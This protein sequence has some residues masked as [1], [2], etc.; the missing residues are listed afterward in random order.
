MT[1]RQPAVCEFLR[2]GGTTDDLLKRYGVVSKRHRAHPNLV[3]LKYNQIASP[4]HE[5]IVQ[6][7][8][9]IVL[10]E[11]DDW[12]V[13]SRA[14]NKFFNH[15][16]GHAAEID[17]ATARVQEKLDGSLCVLYPYAGAWYVAT[18]GT[19][20]GSGDVNGHGLR[21]SDY[22]HRTLASHVG[23]RSVP[24]EAG[25]YCFFF[26]LTGPINRVVVVHSQPGLTLL[27]ARRRDTWAEVHPSAVAHLFPGVPV[28]REYG[29]QSVDEI[30]ASFAEMSP[31]SQIWRLSLRRPGLG[32][33]RSSRKWPTTSSG[34]GT[35]RRRRTSPSQ[36]PRPAAPRRSSRSE[37]VRP[38]RRPSF[39]PASTSTS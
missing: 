7:C 36:R 17:W 11:A 37:T 14:F 5:S 30:A 25:D 9:G 6:E 35:S 28:V 21:F 8:R 10:D 18:T 24:I 23:D 4:M 16:E 33:A 32:S 20:D 19:P 39:S 2:S 22:F 15:G 38:P 29:L 1:M 3:L 27:G 26:E 34:S 31:H 12:T 13:V